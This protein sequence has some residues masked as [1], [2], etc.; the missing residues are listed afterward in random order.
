M[1][2]VAFVELPAPTAGVSAWKR[3]PVAHNDFIITTNRRR[4]LSCQEL[5]IEAL[6]R[7]ST[8]TLSHKYPSGAP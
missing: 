7:V 2:D 5:Q 3:L 1:P 6:K 8:L 4:S